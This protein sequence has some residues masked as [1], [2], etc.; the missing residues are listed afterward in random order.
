MHAH[1]DRVSVLRMRFEKPVQ[2]VRVGLL[3]KV[4]SDVEGLAEN[5]PQNQLPRTRPE[6]DA[7]SSET[8]VHSKNADLQLTRH[9]R[10][11]SQQQAGHDANHVGDAA[12]RCELGN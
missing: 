6:R 2:L 5:T 8:G 4:F 1:F 3:S 12:M 9:A 7:G 11:Q 10:R